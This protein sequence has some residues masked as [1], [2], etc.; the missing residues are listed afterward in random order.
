MR[1]EKV[2]DAKKQQ[3]REQLVYLPACSGCGR[4]RKPRTHIDVVEPLDQIICRR[5]GC[6]RLKGL[7]KDMSKPGNLVI[8]V[9]HYHYGESVPETVPQNKVAEL[10]GGSSATGRIELPGELAKCEYF[11]TERPRR[12]RTILEEPPRVELSTKPTMAEVMY[13]MQQRKRG[14]YADGII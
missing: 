8:N 9:N 4:N 14:A 6:E 13:A 5:P 7:I 1:K 2:R 12:L 10:P 11:G 3:E